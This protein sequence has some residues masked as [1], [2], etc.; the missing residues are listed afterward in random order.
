MFRD[1][2]HVPKSQ[3]HLC[4]L[5][6]TWSFGPGLPCQNLTECCSL[7]EGLFS[8]GGTR[9]RLLASTES[10][11]P[12]VLI[13]HRSTLLLLSPLWGPVE[14]WKRIISSSKREFK[15]MV[16]TNADRMGTNSVVEVRS[17][18]S[19]ENCSFCVRSVEEQVYYPPGPSRDNSR[20]VDW[21]SVL[22]L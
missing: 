5:H 7:I 22:L 16:P 20:P 17:V 21:E 9:S 15:A 18:G 10:Q 2:V 1:L 6:E 19:E 4:L 11:I 12:Q 13:G 14:K 8:T 3:R